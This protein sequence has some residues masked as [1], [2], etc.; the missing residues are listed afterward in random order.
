MAAV[1]VLSGTLHGVDAIPIDVE[2]DLT[3]RL[4]AIS[5]VG[6]AASAVKENAER[7]RSA[8][9][10]LGVDFPTK[11][12]VIN[13]APADLKKDGTALDLPMALGL[14]AAAEQIPGASVR[15][16]L[17]VG[18]L[19]LDGELR[20]IRGALSL[21]LLAREHGHTLVVPKVNARAAAIVPGA[22]VVGANALAEIVA[23]LRGEITL[24]E[25][26]ANTGIAPPSGLDLA[27]VKGH[28]VAKQALEIA[29]AGAHHTLLIG[30]PGC[31]KSMLARRLPTL[32]PP[33]TFPEAL[34]TTRVHSAAGLL[35][36]HGTLLAERPFRSPHNSVSVAGLVGDSSLR[37]GE[38]SLAHHGVLFL[39]E[40]PEFS[41]S[42]IEVL[43]QP[44]EDGVVRLSKAR[45]SVA[46]PA[47]ITLVLAC[48]PCPCGYRGAYSCRC[49]DGDV[50]RYL[51]RLSG[52]ILDRIDLYVEMSPL[53]SRELLEAPSGETSTTVRERVVAARVRQ[54]ERGQEVPNARLDAAGL[55]KFAPLSEEVRELL[56]R[57]GETKMLSSRATT[58]AI[59][60]AR[61]IADIEGKEAIEVGHAALALG[62]RPPLALG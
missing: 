25:E 30:P 9:T 46:Y 37:P 8:V 31:G 18:E 39:D 59:K 16:I 60:V 32:L 24:S 10:A 4:P 53:T 62:F 33:M 2:V 43:R 36:R 41:R 58:R 40:A 52:P 35:D 17:A 5:I 19:A 34:E 11:R 14:L 45:G 42:S 3:K 47:A 13:L 44:L 6:L 29:A 55:S 56:A 27:D 15:G 49:P 57:A 21:A 61:T 26:P 12:V 54:H 48:N 28:A 38:V 23:W 51:R 20:P 50:A 1:R 7:M 22:R